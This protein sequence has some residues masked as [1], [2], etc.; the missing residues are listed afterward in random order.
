MIDAMSGEQNAE[1]P[2][3]LGGGGIRGTSTSLLKVHK[4]TK[5]IFKQI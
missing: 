3:Q 2:A 4:F 5:I 1:A